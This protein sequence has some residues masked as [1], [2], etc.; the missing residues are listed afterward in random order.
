MRKKNFQRL[1]ITND[2][3]THEYLDDDVSVPQRLI[4]TVFLIKELSGESPAVS[5]MLEYIAKIKQF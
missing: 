4:S 3:L 2:H 1:D 5:V